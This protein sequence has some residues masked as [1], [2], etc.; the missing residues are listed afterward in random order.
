MDVTNAGNKRRQNVRAIAA[1]LNQSVLL[2]EYAP[3]ARVNTD[4]YIFSLLCDPEIARTPARIATQ[5]Y[6]LSSV[7]WL[8]KRGLTCGRSD[9][10]VTESSTGGR[11][12]R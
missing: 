3:G 8:R 12:V 4:N 9:C 6:T 2:F 10:A 5:H 7:G 1:G 11:A